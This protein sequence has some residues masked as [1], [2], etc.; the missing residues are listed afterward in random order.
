M[1]S[2]GRRGVRRRRWFLGSYV[3]AQIVTRNN[4]TCFQEVVESKFETISRPCTSRLRR[5]GFAGLCTCK[6]EITIAIA[7]QLALL[8]FWATS[9]NLCFAQQVPFGLFS[10][11]ETLRYGR[12]SEENTVSIRRLSE[13]SRRSAYPLH[14]TCVCHAAA[15]FTFSMKRTTSPQDG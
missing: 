12:G 8:P 15:S 9:N 11:T 7:P 5:G 14:S 1:C 13:A 4:A 3:G 2:R 6:L 10:S